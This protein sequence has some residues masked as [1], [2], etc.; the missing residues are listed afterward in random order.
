MKKR[1][2]ISWSVVIIFFLGLITKA[3]TDFNNK[4]AISNVIQIP[5]ESPD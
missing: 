4:E 3:W 1:L 5:I 2:I